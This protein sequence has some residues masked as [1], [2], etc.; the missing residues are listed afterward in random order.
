M[1]AVHWAMMVASARLWS[2]PAEALD[3]RIC[4]RSLAR[5]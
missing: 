3:P 1:P 2:V 4:G 5:L